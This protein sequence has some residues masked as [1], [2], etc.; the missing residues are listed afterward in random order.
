MFGLSCGAGWIEGQHVLYATGFCWSGWKPEGH[1]YVHR[2]IRLTAAK[3]GIIW[4]AEEAR[5]C[6]G[7]SIETMRI[8]EAVSMKVQ[9]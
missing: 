6:D 2:L 3:R 7:M 8:M 4:R 5:K 1:R 9:N